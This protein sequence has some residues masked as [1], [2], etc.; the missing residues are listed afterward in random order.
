MGFQA[1]F[2]LFGDIVS[3]FLFILILDDGNYLTRKLSSPTSTLLGMRLAWRQL[4][5]LLNI[6][7][8][9]KKVKDLGSPSK[10]LA[11]CYLVY[12]FQKS[13]WLEF[14]SVITR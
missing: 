10:G 3:S 1:K 12:S 7:L 9:D 5:C 4:M 8:L 11:L 13:I 2:H 6:I 14:I